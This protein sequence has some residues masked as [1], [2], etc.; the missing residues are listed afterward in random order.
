VSYS[1]RSID[2]DA[3]TFDIERLQDVGSMTLTNQDGIVITVLQDAGGNI[4]GDVS[5]GTE[6]FATIS[7]SGGLITIRFSDGVLESI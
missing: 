6:E 1:G 3:G 2:L 5:R 4:S 7:E